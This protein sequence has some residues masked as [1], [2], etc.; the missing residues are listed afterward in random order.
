MHG[1]KNDILAI[2][3]FWQNGTFEPTH[4]IQIFWGGRKTSVKRYEDDMY[5]KYF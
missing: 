3:Q 2:F 1:F 5:K 4:E